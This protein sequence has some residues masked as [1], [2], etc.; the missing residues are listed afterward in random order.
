[1]TPVE[2]FRAMLQLPTISRVDT[3]MTEWQHFD[4]FVTLLPQLYPGVHKSLTREIVA[5]HSLLY[6]WA[7]R[8]ADAPTVLLAHYD[9]V[10]ASDER[11][12]H[13]P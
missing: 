13:P 2:R 8:S 5:D 6:R 4:R 10:A 7:G 3:G 9:V 11:W 1:M 12:E